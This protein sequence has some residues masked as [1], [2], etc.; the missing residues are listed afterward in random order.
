MNSLDATFIVCGIPIVCLAEAIL[1]SAVGGI[2]TFLEVR[3]D[4]SSVACIH[5]YIC[6]EFLFT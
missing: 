4:L 1:Q 2:K 6:F 5:R 3:T